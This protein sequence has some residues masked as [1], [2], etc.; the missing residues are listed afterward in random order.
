MIRSHDLEGS[1][2]SVIGDFVSRPFSN[3]LAVKK[4]LSCIFFYESGREINQCGLS[5]TIWSDDP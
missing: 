4:D 3:V 5:R 1:Y 2:Q